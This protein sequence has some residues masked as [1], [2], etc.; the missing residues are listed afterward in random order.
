MAGGRTDTYLLDRGGSVLAGRYT[1]TD[2]LAVGGM[3]SVWIAE[4]LALK[5]RV[6]VK[7]HE[8]W[9]PGGGDE[10]RA[11]ARF[12]EEARAL[13]RVRH[14]N[15]TEL[16]E[17][18]RTEEGEPYLIMELLQ[19][20]SLAA[21]MRTAGRLPA[22]EAVHITTGIL[23]GLE[24][25]HAAGILHRDVKP[26]NIYLHREGVR[27]V[28]KL[29]D[30]GLARRD[31]PPAPGKRRQ[32]VGT[33]GYMAPEQCRGLSDL[34]ARVDLY[35]AAVTLYEMLCERLPSEG[36]NSAERMVW[37]ASKPP[38][39]LTHRDPELEGPLADV[40][41]RALAIPREER[42]ATARALRQ[43]IQRAH[44]AG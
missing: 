11:L 26:E 27:V 24:A 40:V 42:Y 38:V 39:P 1:V 37:T 29:L 43:A 5:R 18:G 41:M 32:A 15:V 25:V 23:S 44:E 21:R 17:V 28:P 10:K 35:A 19:G 13:S 16:F 34:D 31:L 20:Q 3:G 30:F 14:K 8:E 33:P 6:V 4:H 9:E 7:F 12:M 2:L 22:R 36:T